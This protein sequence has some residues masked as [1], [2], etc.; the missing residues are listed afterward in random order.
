ML[1]SNCAT[2]ANIATLSCIQEIVNTKPTR[3]RALAFVLI[4]FHFTRPQSPSILAHCVSATLINYED[5][6]R[7]RPPPPPLSW[8]GEHTNQSQ[9][10]LW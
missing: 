10:H 9:W 8:G 1:C 3:N 5:Q 6:H 7:R 2:T 4:F